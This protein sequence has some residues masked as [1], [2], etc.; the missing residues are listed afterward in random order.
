[1]IAKNFPVHD[2]LRRVNKFDIEAY[3]DMI[4]REAGLDSVPDNWLDELK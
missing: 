4:S 2:N 1:M 3:D